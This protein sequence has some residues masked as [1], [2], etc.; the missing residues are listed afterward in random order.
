LPSKF[1]RFNPDIQAVQ[2]DEV[3]VIATNELV[4]MV[5]VVV[6][7]EG[8]IITRIILEVVASNNQENMYSGSYY[9]TTHMYSGSYYVTTIQ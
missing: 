9:V 5:V 1:S 3:M 8:V 7:V 4:E 2:L 6:V